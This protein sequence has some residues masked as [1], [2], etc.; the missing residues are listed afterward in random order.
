MG[1]TLRAQ[2]PL[3]PTPAPQQSAVVTGTV[4]TPG[5]D[6]QLP[7]AG[8][9]VTLH[10]VAPDRS[11]AVDSVRTDAAGQYKIRYQ[12][13]A[14]D[15]AIYFA[16]AVYR[17][18]AYFSAP[19]QGAQV[20]GEAGEITV[21]ETTSN[22]VDFH[23][24][25]H[26]VVVSAPRPDGTRALV[27]VWEL[28][29]DT[30]VTVV[31]RDSTTAVW[32]APLPRGATNVS[33]GQGDVAPDAIVQRGDR[34]ALIA[35]FGPGVKQITYSYGLPASAFPFTLPIE[36]P[37]SVLEVLLEEPAAQLTSGALR[38]MDAATTQGRTFKRFL[39]QDVATGTSVRISVPASTATMRQTVLIALALVISL[40]MA[41]TLARA[42]LFRGVSRPVLAAQAPE[43][44]ESMLAAIA[45]LDARHERG[46]PMLHDAQ[47][48]AQRIELKARLTAAL[49][50][51]ARH[52]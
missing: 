7:I 36:R 20:S 9:M 4:E 10:R 44:T 37:T 43:T 33:G 42:L 6:R 31:G 26:H 52:T 1:V 12:R 38:A 29:N 32:S 48:A 28:S 47:Y 46:D 8:L 19:L 22:A 35:A 39:G 11:G 23:V 15:G 41:G 16:A 45:F 25:G 5:R 2:H 50:A 51:E 3:L 27:E 21:F 49:V 13:I 34:A 18:I 24:Q 40:V 17:G 14:S 30:T